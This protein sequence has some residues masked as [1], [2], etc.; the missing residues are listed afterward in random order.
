MVDALLASGRVDVNLAAVRGHE[1]VVAALLATGQVDAHMRD[2]LHE[3]TALEFA[4]QA[5][6]D[7][8]A[9]LLRGQRRRV[10]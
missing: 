7:A 3:W 8:I 2:E 5:G 1:K 9:Q 10:G 6:H 4:S